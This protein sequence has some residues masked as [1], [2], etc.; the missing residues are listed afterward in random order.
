[1]RAQDKSLELRVGFLICVGLIAL[2][3]MVIYFQQF[4]AHRSVYV[5]HATFTFAGGIQPGTPVRIAGY[6]VG[7]VRTVEV[8][9]GEPTPEAV[10][11]P[12]VITAREDVEALVGMIA[13]GPT[14][15]PRAHAAG[16]PR[17]W[18]T[19]W[20]ADGTTLGRSYFP[21]TSELMG[22]VV[23]ARELRALLDRYLA[24]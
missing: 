23:V 15:P 19:F 7:K 17:Y 6:H 11:K 8:W 21:E 24:R 18:L 22:G 5:L 16:E 3:A 1:M 12:A 20:L 2:G 4:K 10:G 14:R 9:R 13:R